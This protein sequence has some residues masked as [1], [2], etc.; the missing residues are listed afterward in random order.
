MSS[1]N[2]TTMN[3]DQA[4]AVTTQYF[5]AWN[6]ADAAARQALLEQCW[7]DDAVYVD[8]TV[9]LKGREALLAHIAKVRS[10]RP[11]A[12]LELM[13]AIDVHHNVLRFL[14]RLVRTDGTAGDISIDFGEIGPDG[15]L[16]KM[17]GFFGSAPAA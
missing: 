4:I 17:I 12:R 9:Q 10:A 14:W 8:P 11:G 13:S 5:D 16:V 15:R 6:E 3:A 7:S 1:I 2:G